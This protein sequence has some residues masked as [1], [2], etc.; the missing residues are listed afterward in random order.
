MKIPISILAGIA[1]AGLYAQDKPGNPALVSSETELAKLAAA[2]TGT[3]K[4]SVE[5][6]FKKPAQS[7]FQF[8]P[9]GLYF[10]YKERDATGKNHVYVKNTTTNEVKR[11]IEEKDQLIRGYFWKGNNRLLFMMDKGGDENYHVYAVNLD[12]S[13]LKDLTPFDGV[14]AGVSHILKDQGDFVIM[15]M[16]KDNPQV[17]EPYKVNINTGEYTRLFEN[18]DPQNPI[19]GYDF[20]KDGE[21]KAYTQQQNATETVLFY[22]TA[23]DKPFE[24]VNR[25]SWKTDFYIISFDYTTPNPN[26]AYILTNKFGNTREILLY[27]FGTRKT[28]KKVF[29]DKTFD[30]DGL[31][32]SRKRGYE[33]DY[34]F[35]SGEK[36]V[37]VPVS[38]TAKKIHARFKKQFGDKDFTITGI[39]DNEDKYLVYVGSDKLYGVYYFYDATKDTFKEIMNLA[40]QLKEEDMAEMRPIKFKSRDGLTIYGYLTIPKGASKTN[41]VPLILNP[42]GGPYGVRDSW[43]FNP[44]TQLFASRGYATIQ[45]NYRGSGGYGKEFF[46]AG[47]K[48]IGRN[49]LNDLEDG[50]AY[51][52]TLGFIDENK[53]AVYGGS[54]GGLA[55]LGS[56]VKTPDLYTCGVD[57]VGVSNLFTFFKSFPEYWKPFLGQVYEQWYDENSPEDQKIMTAVSPALNVDKIKKPLFVVQG[58]NDPRVNIDESDQVVQNLRKRNIATPYMVKYDEGHGFGH[59]GNQI[60]MYKC[61]MGFFVQHLK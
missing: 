36:D 48:Q 7:S 50:V 21:L 12:G 52:K 58:A 15:D 26:D 37:T 35:Y 4:Y 6:Y 56:L 40:P 33:V 30:V 39:T 31:T 9:N 29:S 61:M 41:K 32:T 5:D 18:K 42:H 20:D 27:D 43:G 2:E 57:Y 54:Y 46:L 8:S 38:A 28:I 3:Y 44:E 16:N 1:S 24:E 10:S 53:V 11:V 17:F 23:K 13:N 49:M 45:V 60:E 34:Y 22:R 55:T 59:E 51:A 14:R 47:N 25:N 19:M